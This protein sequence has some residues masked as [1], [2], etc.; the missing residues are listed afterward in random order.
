MSIKKLLE[1][2]VIQAFDAVGDLAVTMSL[3]KVDNPS[4]D[5]TTSAPTNMAPSTVNVIG[6]ELE[7]KKK[8]SSANVIEKS[9]I[10][11]SV[12]L[13]DIKGFDTLLIGGVA[14]KIGTVHFSNGFINMFKVWRQ[15]NG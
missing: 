8:S 7:D 3:Q 12:A 4:Y 15:K 5:F 6:V 11:K 13:L 10:V 9:V 1:K 2:G 14:W